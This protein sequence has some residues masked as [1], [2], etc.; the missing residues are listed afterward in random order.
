MCRPMC[1]AL[2]SMNTLYLRLRC[3]NRL[4][5]ETGAGA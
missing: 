5:A 3:Y 4:D 1:T 2:W